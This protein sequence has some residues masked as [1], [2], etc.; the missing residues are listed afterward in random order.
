[1]GQGGYIEQRR[2]LLFTLPLYINTLS[3]IMRVMTHVLYLKYLY[4]KMI[5]KDLVRSFLTFLRIITFRR[6]SAQIFR[7][8]GV[9][10]PDGT[11]GNAQPID[12]RAGSSRVRA[13]VLAPVLGLHVVRRTAVQCG[14]C[15]RRADRVRG[16]VPV[17]GA[18]DAGRPVH[19]PRTPELPT[20]GRAP[21]SRPAHVGQRPPLRVVRQTVSAERGGSGR[22]AHAAADV[23]HR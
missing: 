5:I 22:H 3:F 1:M 15:C 23:N 11:V 14:D 8:G 21:P 10:E 6:D 20:A 7:S 17:Y 16:R 12:R 4:T 18:A 19:V 9:P 13:V 2:S